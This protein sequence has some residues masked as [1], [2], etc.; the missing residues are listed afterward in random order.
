MEP[1]IVSFC[2]Q[3]AIANGIVMGGGGA[4]VVP[5]K[6]SA[7]TEKTVGTAELLRYTR[8]VDNLLN[9]YG[10]LPCSCLNMVSSFVVLVN[11]KRLI[12]CP[13]GFCCA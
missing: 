11:I 7:V 4:M 5:L 6:F 1:I 3:V 10:Y 12:F 2:I 9:L 8:H 13:I